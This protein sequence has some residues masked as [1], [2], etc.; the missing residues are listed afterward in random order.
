MRWEHLVL[1]DWNTSWGLC[2][3]KGCWGQPWD[4]GRPGRRSALDACPLNSWMKNDRFDLFISV[5]VRAGTRIYNRR[6]S[7]CQNR[8]KKKSRER[9]QF[10]FFLQEKDKL[11]ATKTHKLLIRTSQIECQVEQLGFGIKFS[12]KGEVGASLHWQSGANKERRII[13]GTLI[14]FFSTRSPWVMG[15]RQRWDV[16]LARRGVK[17]EQLKPQFSH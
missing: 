14:C 12:Q 11:S 9:G 16:E 6:W 4:E 3:F 15:E 2:L 1:K 17:H 7:E 8:G 13:N 10:V 5:W